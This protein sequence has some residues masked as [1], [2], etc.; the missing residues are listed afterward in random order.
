VAHN[1]LDQDPVQWRAFI[2]AVF[3]LWGS[4]ARNFVY[5]EPLIELFSALL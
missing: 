2:F 5:F 3:K 4:V 1:E